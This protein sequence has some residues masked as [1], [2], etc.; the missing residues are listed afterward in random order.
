[1][2]KKKTKTLLKKNDAT[3]HEKAIRDIRIVL[4]YIAATLMQFIQ[5]SAACQLS[6]AYQ[7]AEHLLG[8]LF[9][10]CF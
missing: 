7:Q 6:D 2:F 9:L 4:N 10:F 1:M 3:S 8:N 5:Y